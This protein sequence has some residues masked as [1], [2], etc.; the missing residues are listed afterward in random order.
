M[1]MGGGGRGGFHLCLTVWEACVLPVDVHVCVRVHVFMRGTATVV[2]EA[3][4]ILGG[5]CCQCS[6]VMKRCS[7]FDSVF[8]ASSF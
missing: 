5:E 1:L 4:W 3:A 2:G 6:V 7:L 8:M